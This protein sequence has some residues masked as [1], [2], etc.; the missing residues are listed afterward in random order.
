METMFNWSKPDSVNRVEFYL[1]DKYSLLEL[2]KYI[3]EFEI[4]FG[5]IVE[6][7]TNENL[8]LPKIIATMKT[9]VKDIIEKI[10]I[11]RMEL[12]SRTDEFGNTS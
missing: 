8:Y 10:N 4:M 12:E 9:V 3:N 7:S 2:F 6:K 1:N 5:P 11:I